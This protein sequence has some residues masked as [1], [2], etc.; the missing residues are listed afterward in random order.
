M[1]GSFAPPHAD[2]LSKGATATSNDSPSYSEFPKA[3]RFVTR[4]SR[5]SLFHIPAWS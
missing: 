2:H 4:L 5:L 1:R 3:H